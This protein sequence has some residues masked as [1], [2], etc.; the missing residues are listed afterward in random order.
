MRRTHPCFERSEGM[1]HGLPAQAHRVGL[2]FQPILHCLKNR[3]VLP[4]RD[5][6]ILAGRALRLDRTLRTSRGPVLVYCHST[7]DC[8]E[9]LDGARSIR[10]TVFVLIRD[11]GKVALVEAAVSLA[12]R[13]QRLGHQGAN[14]GLFA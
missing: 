2:A 1:L 10:T 5:P 7:L 11:V 14:T 4:A 3:F 6:S 8:G 12:G 9:T 13:S